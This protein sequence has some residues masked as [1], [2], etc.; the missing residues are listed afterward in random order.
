M[1]IHQTKSSDRKNRLQNNN[2]KHRYK[3]TRPPALRQESET[4][5]VTIRNRRLRIRILTGQF[6]ENQSDFIDSLDDYPGSRS[7]ISQVLYTYRVVR[8]VH[9]GIGA[10]IDRRPGSVRSRFSIVHRPSSRDDMSTVRRK[11]R[12]WVR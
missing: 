12:R 4:H 9:R 10:I 3:T 6:F 5:T 1:C 8:Y 7:G 11:N 2:N